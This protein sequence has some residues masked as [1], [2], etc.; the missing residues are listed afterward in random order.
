MTPVRKI[1]VIPNP[2]VIV[3]TVVL[4]SAAKRWAWRE[5]GKIFTTT[6][7]ACGF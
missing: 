2:V 5:D 3:G 1:G 6:N 4:R 7:S